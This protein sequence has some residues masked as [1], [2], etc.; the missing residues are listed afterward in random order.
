M[1]ELNLA[2]STGEGSERPHAQ[3]LIFD[4][5]SKI[6]AQCK[7]VL[8]RMSAV[9]SFGAG[10]QTRPVHRWRLTAFFW[11]FSSSFLLTVRNERDCV[12]VLAEYVSKSSSCFVWKRIKRSRA[13][14]KI[15]RDA[16]FSGSTP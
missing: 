8:D 5:R 4:K 1:A 12:C 16:E 9:L 7:S 3:D 14:M 11:G 6:I 13:E 2:I 15:K 10:L